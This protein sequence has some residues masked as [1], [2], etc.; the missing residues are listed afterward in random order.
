MYRVFI[1]NIDRPDTCAFSFLID[2]LN[3]AMDRAHDLLYL[4]EQ[5]VRVAVEKVDE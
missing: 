3:K 2:D 1:E 4:C 5:R